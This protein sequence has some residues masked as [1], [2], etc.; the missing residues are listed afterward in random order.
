MTVPLSGNHLVMMSNA[1]WHNDDKYFALVQR[2]L[3][4][5]FLAFLAFTQRNLGI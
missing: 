3:Q 4:I 2:S 1:L 5:H